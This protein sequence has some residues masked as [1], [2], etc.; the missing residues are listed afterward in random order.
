M[1][2][3][4]RLPQ[5]SLLPEL[6]WTFTGIVIDA[7]PMTNLA[8][9]LTLLVAVLIVVGCSQQSAKE[10][11]A[12]GQIIY[13]P[14]EDNFV[15]PSTETPSFVYTNS[16]IDK[17][18][19]YRLFHQR[20]V[21]IPAFSDQTLQL[22]KLDRSSQ[23]ESPV[24]FLTKQWD[25]TESIIPRRPGI[26][27]VYAYEDE[28]FPFNDSL[29]PNEFSFDRVVLMLD[30]HRE[31]DKPK[32]LRYLDNRAE[33]EMHRSIA[34]L[35]RDSEP[36]ARANF[37]FDPLI[38]RVSKV[39]TPVIGAERFDQKRGRSITEE[40]ATVR[41]DHGQWSGFPDRSGQ[42]ATLRAEWNNLAET[43]PWT[44]TLIG[45]RGFREGYGETRAF[46]VT[47]ISRPTFRGEPI[48]VQ[49]FEPP[50]SAEALAALI[51]V[52]VDFGGRHT[53]NLVILIDGEIENLRHS[54]D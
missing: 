34:K 52:S 54:S 36:F 27:I 48:E 1:I 37:D 21:K 25:Q 33:Y 26:E 44:V 35:T 12:N 41:L 50:P 24:F 39:Y 46:V 53:G 3:R 2:S 32:F 8:K 30:R 20:S 42:P 28:F 51:N 19:G 9:S 5:P 7:T 4:Y 16:I 14:R 38:K 47:D 18:N 22:W 17:T 40:G 45:L 49:S 6:K 10:E 15:R 11:M 13:N 31:K 43:N 23:K 29:R